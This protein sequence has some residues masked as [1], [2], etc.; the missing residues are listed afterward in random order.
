[1]VSGPEMARLIGEFESSTKKRQDEDWHHH[2]Q[3]EH[4]QMRFARDVKALIGVMEEMG[5]PFNELSDDLLV[6]DSR[7]I[8]DTAVADTVHRIEQLGLEQY[9]N[10]VEERLIN[11]TKPITDPLK[12]NNLPLF[13]RPPIREKSSKQLQLSSLKNN[14]SLFSRL[15]IASQTRNSDLDEFFKHENQACP[16]ALSQMGALRTGTKSDLLSCLQDLVNESISSPTVQVT[17]TILD[18]AAIVNML[19]PGTAK[20]FQEYATNVFL[21]YVMTQLQHVTRLDI[22][23]D[24]YVPESL[25]AN[26][27]SKR[28]KG[29]RRR[30]EPSSAIPGNW[31]AFLRIDENK[32]EL[33]SFLA[34]RVAHMDTHKHV[35]TTHHVDVLC[36]NRQDVSSLA[37]C[38]HEEAD[39]RMLLHLEDAVHQGH[40]KV[41]I[42]TVDT[43]V[44]VLAIS[45]AQ[46][47]KISEL[48][49][50]FGTGKNFRFLA[51]HEMART[52]GPDWCKAL[53]IFHAFTG[54][55]TVSYF[56]GR[57]KRTAWATWKAYEDVT[58]AFCALVARPTLQTIDE[59]LD[60]LERFVVLLYDRTSSLPS[61]DEARKQLF[62]QKG[63]TIDGLP[64]TGA[65]LIQHIK[66]ATYQAGH[67][68]GQ[69]MIASPELPSPSE[70]GW[71]KKAEGGWEAYWTALPEATQACRELLRCGCK[72]GCSGRC[73]CNKAALQ[74]TALC[75]PIKFCII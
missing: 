18:G 46:R 71:S 70:W 72:K 36:T 26:A 14:C 68:W 60:K 54:C 38:T 75:A 61:V 10:Y 62:T 13:S 43:D 2:E 56:G 28:G 59:W 58:P 24:E 45:S 67:C 6:L 29:V 33:F 74:C 22:V 52:L 4:V 15:Y 1:M 25:K 21:P 50:A 51:A 48:W 12:R 53:P 30:V 35:I 44:V 39:T 19:R 73:R 7:N 57:G 42:R 69:L 63:R 32:T 27:R 65:A 49:V 55:D 5:N 31:Q 66:R 9:E 11:H 3:K 41:S 17:C 34:T 23:W 37:P 8:A 64:P 20:T 47:L 16:P 40:N